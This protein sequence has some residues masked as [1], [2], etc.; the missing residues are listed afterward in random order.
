MVQEVGEER[1]R[2]GVL[3]AGAADHA[4]QDLRR[5]SAVPGAVA[6]PLLAVHD[7]RADCLLGAPV[8]G[9]NPG[10]VEEREEVLA[11]SLKVLEK[12]AVRVMRR[13][14]LKQLLESG[15]E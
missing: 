12:L 1:D 7:G 15:L 2:V 13:V 14:A 6:A 3:L 9:L 5:V 10:G 11:L 8:R 4:H